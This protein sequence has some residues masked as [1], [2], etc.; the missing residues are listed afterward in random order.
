MLPASITA[1]GTDAFKGCDSLVTVYYKGTAEQRAAITINDATINAVSQWKYNYCILHVDN[2]NYNDENSGFTASQPITFEKALT[3]INN[4]QGHYHIFIDYPFYEAKELPATLN[5]K[6]LSIKLEGINYYSNSLSGFEGGNVPLTINTSVPVTIKR[7]DICYGK[8]VGLAISGNEGS[9]PDVTIAD[10]V[11]IY[12]NE[13]EN[14]NAKG[15]GVYLEKGTLRMKGGMISYNKIKGSGY[16]AGIYI[17]NGATFIMSG[18]QIIGN[19]I[20]SGQGTGVYVNGTFKMEGR[21]LVDAANDVYLPSGKAIEISDK[22]TPPAAASGITAKITPQTYTFGMQMLKLAKVDGQDITTV[23]LDTVGSHFTVSP[24]KDGDKYEID[25]TGRLTTPMVEVG[26]TYFDGSETVEGSLIFTQGRELA[27]QNLLVCSH[28]VTQ[29]EYM[30]VMNTNPSNFK[31]DQA[32]GEVQDNRPVEKVTWYDAINY[33]NSRSSAE[34]LTPC[35]TIDN[36]TT[37]ATVTCNFEANG[38]R[39]PTEAEWEYLA[40]EGCLTAQ[41]QTTYSGTNYAW[42]SVD[43]THEVMKKQPNGRGL[44]DMC[45]NVWEW[46][47]DWYQFPVETNT[48]STGPETGVKRCLRGGSYASEAL[49]NEVEENCRGYMEPDNSASVY[50]FRVVR[51]KVSAT[52]HTV[53]FNTNGGTDL[54]NITVWDGYYL[55]KP[56]IT[57]DGYTFDGWFSDE[58]CNNAYDFSLPVTESVTLKAKWLTNYNITFDVEGITKTLSFAE[59]ATPKY[60]DNDPTKDATAQYEYSFSGWN[61]ELTTVTGNATYTAVFTPAVR[62]YDITFVIDENPTV[63]SYEYGQTPSYGSTPTKTADAQYT[64]TFDK[65]SPTIA[66][67]TGEA[68]YTA[69]FTHTVRKYQIKFVN[70]N[71]TELQSSEVAY[72]TKPTYNGSTPTKPADSNYTY[73]F[74]GWSPTITTVTGAQTYTAQFSATA[75]PTSVKFYFSASGSGTVTAKVNGSSI[76]SGTEL[77]IGTTVSLTASPDSGYKFLYW[78]H[79]SS[80]STS[81]SITISAST[82]SVQ[83]IFTLNQ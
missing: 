3:M 49:S 29:G 78:S 61:P 23:K 60:G 83:A 6:A 20:T 59:G 73:S 64:Y 48:P 43:K 62:K 82:T 33:C 56:N 54:A 22:L 9:V 14:E 70:Y 26:G 31:T 15:G 51:T 68:T 35:Y 21:A 11:Y 74:S 10:E 39:L 65:W 12:Q 38:Y 18:G 67:V 32:E 13:T 45:G 71:G 17:E 41:Q 46:C 28:E 1:I 25:V 63:K 34:N 36:S 58:D 52:S 27:I 57:R 76:S 4:P 47:W 30:A 80:T 66:T 19:S 53:S 79:N 55:S 40:R 72:G 42:Y 44:Y 7:M 75:K 8:S 2:R 5:G 37:P 16:G 50:G 77:S 69:E 81:T 24:Q